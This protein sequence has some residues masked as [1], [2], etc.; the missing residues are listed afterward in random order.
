M[1][2]KNS[3]Y[4]KQYNRR[5]VLSLLQR[6]PLSRAELSRQMGLTRAA[7]SLI[8]EE[9][10]AEGLICPS[11]KSM[12]PAGP[13]RAPT[14]LELCAGALFAV[15][16]SLSRSGAWVGLEDLKGN[17]LAHEQVTDQTPAGL[18]AAISKVIEKTP[19]DKILGIGISA[20]G[21]VDSAKGVILNP[22]D[23]PLWSNCPIGTLLSDAL[24]LPVYLEKDAN[25]AALFNRRNGD[26]EEKDDFLLL[27]M[28]G[29]VGSGVISQGKLL[30]F[31][32]LG[33]TSIC[34]D[35]PV[36]SCG[37]RGCLEA[38]ASINNILK[39]FQYGSWEELMASPKAAQVLSMQAEY[40]ATAIGNCANMIPI[41][42]VLLDGKMLAYSD[43]LLHLVAQ[44]LEGRCMS[45]AA[46]ELLPALSGPYTR[47]QS[48]CSIVFSHYLEEE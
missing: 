46:P 15:G 12:Q 10:I 26:F 1:E 47:L 31:T 3:A 34:Y 32:E 44:R 45:G 24:N 18:I 25:A 36:C 16:V 27:Y 2:G 39:Q 42:A 19:K 4:T 41:G 30:R 29:G 22:P 37:N 35:G 13:G 21:P 20:P 38:Y 7:I 8:T 17:V 40:L 11:E 23:F 14:N 33:H 48:A 28:G 9:L 6:S 5:R 43:R